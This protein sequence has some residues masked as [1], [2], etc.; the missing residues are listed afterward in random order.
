MVVRGR[1]ARP[2]R[3]VPLPV[4]LSGPTTIFVA[5]E[6]NPTLG[7]DGLYCQVIFWGVRKDVEFRPF[8]APRDVSP[9]LTH[10]HQRPAKWA[11]RPHTPAPAAGL[12]FLLR[13]FGATLHQAKILART[14]NPVNP[15][16]MEMTPR[17]KRGKLRTDF[18]HSS[19]R[20]WKSGHNPTRRIPTFPPRRR[21]DFSFSEKLEKSHAKFC[22]KRHAH[23]IKSRKHWLMAHSFFYVLQLVNP[24]FST[25]LGERREAFRKDLKVDT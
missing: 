1:L 12:S 6:N 22:K 18:P 23:L 7:E 10:T 8:R 5:P 2:T 24:R 13:L 3:A 11:G 15:P 4:S 14:R 25:R 19:H 16:L 21:D 17:G 9:Q 20:A